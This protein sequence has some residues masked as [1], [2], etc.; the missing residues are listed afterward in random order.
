MTFY[1]NWH[2]NY[3]RSKIKLSNLLNKKHAF[4]YDL[5]SVQHLLQQIIYQISNK[6]KA[7]DYTADRLYTSFKVILENNPSIQSWANV[8]GVE[9]HI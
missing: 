2:R 6:A 9:R 5:P 1:L 4:K 8:A 7:W 3:N